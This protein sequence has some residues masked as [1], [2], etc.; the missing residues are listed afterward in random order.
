MNAG[1]WV[2]IDPQ[3]VRVIEIT[4]ADGVR[5]Q[6]DAAEV[7]DPSQ[8]RRIIDNYLFRR[9]ARRERQRYGSQPR[10]VFGRRAFLIKR[11][12]FRAVHEALENDRTIPNSSESSRGD[13]K[14]IPHKVKLRKLRLL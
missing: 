4:G 10:G 12:T 7:D 2:Q 9:T 8:S 3:F 13:R 6:F 1:T 11:L 5:V 14:V